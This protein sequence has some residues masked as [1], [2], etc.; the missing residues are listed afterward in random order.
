MASVRPRQS[1]HLICEA[2]RRERAEVSWMDRELGNQGDQVLLCPDFLDHFRPF[3][4][5]FLHTILY[6]FTTIQ[7]WQNVTS[8]QPMLL[9]QNHP[10]STGPGDKVE[11]EKRWLETPTVYPTCKRRTET[12]R[13]KSNPRKTRQLLRAKICLLSVKGPVC[14]CLLPWKT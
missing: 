4:F 14:V 1:S 7:M 6:F 13:G 12:L 9:V 11:A 10:K 8:K 2:Q 5:C 3:I